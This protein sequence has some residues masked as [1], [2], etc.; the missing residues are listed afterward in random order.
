MD[1]ETSGTE[2]EWATWV[3]QMSPT[4]GFVFT[5]NPTPPLGDEIV[6]N[7]CYGVTITGSPAAHTV[8]YDCQVL[9]NWYAT[10][11]VPHQTNITSDPYML[12]SAS[13]DDPA[14]N[15]VLY[16][17]PSVRNLRSG[18]HGFRRSCPGEPVRLPAHQLRDGRSAGNL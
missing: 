16:Q 8:Q 15:D 9:S 10:V 2:Y 5:I 3:Y 11:Q 7:P 6:A 14:I 18:V 12:V 1:Y 4:G 17:G 13:S